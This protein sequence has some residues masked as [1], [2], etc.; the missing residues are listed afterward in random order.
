MAFHKPTQHQA[1]PQNPQPKNVTS[2]GGIAE[3]PK[4][5]NVPGYPK[6]AQ[7]MS[8]SPQMALF[9]RFGRLTML[10]LLRL[11]AELQVLE[12]QLLDTIVED[13]TAQDGDIEDHIRR[14]Y[15]KDFRTMRDAVDSE[16]DSVQHDL[17][18]KIANKLQE[19]SKR[20]A[21]VVDRRCWLKS[22]QVKL[23][24]PPLLWRL[25]R[26]QQNDK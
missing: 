7:A 17:P 26:R 18:S 8:S 12:K 9:R 19:Y 13:A 2:S 22:F 4:V 25:P 20:P 10:N 3:K 21:L 11:Q 14:L 1:E 24:R 15:S 6:L 16:G 23:S 5:D